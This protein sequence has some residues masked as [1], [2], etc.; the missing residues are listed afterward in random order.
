M[1]STLIGNH[2]MSM[3]SFAFITLPLYSFQGS[4]A[5]G[6]MVLYEVLEAF[7]IGLVLILDSKTKKSFKVNGHIFNPYIGEEKSP[8]FHSKEMQLS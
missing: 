8:P 7:E 2:S 5:L 4:C 3:T 1:T 6:E